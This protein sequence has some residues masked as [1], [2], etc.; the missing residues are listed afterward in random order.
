MSAAEDEHGY[1][2]QGMGHGER[3]MQYEYD[4]RGEVVRYEMDG[5]MRRPQSRQCD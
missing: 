1:Q 2:E 4:Q 3:D 5:R